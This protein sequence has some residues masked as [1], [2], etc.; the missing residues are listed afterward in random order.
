MLAR[1]VAGQS[2]FDVVEAALWVAYEE[3]ADL[4]VEREVG[5]LH[6][7]A[8]EGAHRV[9]HLPNPFARHDGLQRFFVDDLGFRGNA[10]DYEDPRNSFMNEVLDRRLG[11]PLTLTLIFMELAQAAGF[12]TAGVALPGHFV[13]RLEYAGRVILVD[14]YH[15]AQVL[16]EEDC[17]L[18]VRRCTGRSSLFRRELL[19]GASARVVL[20]RLLLN[21]KHT[22]VGRND[23]GK[24]LGI[25][26]RLLL[27]DATD[28]REIR[29]MGFLKAHLGR[30]GAAI[31]DLETYLSLDPGAADRE[32]VEGRLV[33]LRRKLSETN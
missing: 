27:L 21:L 17:R 20:R 9:A 7:L 26:E 4:D 28:S 14:P 33:W 1:M 5:R 13:A 22:Y 15:G 10:T 19:A 3:Y 24:A 2:S 16:S 23:Y 29:D 8:A 6:L 31:A 18:L 12:R 30:P 32:S 11:I 25:V